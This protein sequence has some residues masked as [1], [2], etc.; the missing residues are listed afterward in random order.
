M[1]TH[2]VILLAGSFFFKA[3]LTQNIHS[4][5]LIYMEG[6]KAKDLLPVVDFIYHG[7]VNVHQ[8]DFNAFL[9]K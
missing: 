1:E 9:A 6:L 7:E 5:P 3:L 2:K 8:E 4:P